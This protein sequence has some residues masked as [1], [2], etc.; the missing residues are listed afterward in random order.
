MNRFPNDTIKIPRE[1]AG[2]K[3]PI[4]VHVGRSYPS[5]QIVDIRLSSAQK[6]DSPLDRLLTAIGDVI[7]EEIT[8]PTDKGSE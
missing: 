5:G 2:L 3:S 4:F 8:S 1:V 6:D 7:T